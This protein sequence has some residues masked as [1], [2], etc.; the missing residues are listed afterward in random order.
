MARPRGGDWLEDEISNLKKNKV[1]VV[2]SL[3]E[4]NEIYD[5]ELNHEEDICKSKNI[6]YI[7]FPIPDRDIPKQNSDTN[8]LIE[9]LTK[10]IDEGQS[11]VIHCRMGIGRSSIIAAS[12]LLKYKFKAKASIENISSI[13]GLKVPDTDSQLLWL[14]SREYRK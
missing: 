11:I 9:A 10:K 3:L 1:G 7:N 13:R 14:M 2:V 12:V 6:T 8:K 4:K 5:L